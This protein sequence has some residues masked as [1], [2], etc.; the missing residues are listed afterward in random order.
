MESDALFLC[1]SQS[2]PLFLA[3][4]QINPITLSQP[5]SLRSF[6]RSEEKAIYL[7]AGQEGSRFS[8]PE[9]ATLLFPSSVISF[10]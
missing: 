4:S 6:P 10:Q 1:F 5:A 2:A 3:L 7:Q 9:A 8:F